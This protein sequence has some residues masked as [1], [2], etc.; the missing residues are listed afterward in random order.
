MRE[1]SSRGIHINAT[2]IFHHN[3]LEIVQ[4]HLMMELKLQTK[5]Q[6]VLYLF[7]FKI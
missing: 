3:K 6:K 1:L 7:C 5:I 2:L 4:L